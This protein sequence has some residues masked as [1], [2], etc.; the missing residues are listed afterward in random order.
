MCNN[1]TIITNETSACIAS[2]FQDQ[3]D[4]RTSVLLVTGVVT[5]IL[6]ALLVAVISVAVHIAMYQCVYKPRLRNLN[7]TS[8][9]VEQSSGNTIV[10]DAID[11]T[12]MQMKDN[13][14]YGTSVAI[15]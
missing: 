1:L 6:T 15:I 7:T 11:E 8:Q 4:A 14:A 10:Y 5:A 3:C 12:A 13:E 9:R 2:Y